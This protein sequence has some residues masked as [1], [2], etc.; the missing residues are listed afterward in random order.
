MWYTRKTLD[1]LCSHR[2]RTVYLIATVI[3]VLSASRLSTMA[4]TTDAVAPLNDNFA[5]PQVL[6]GFS[7][8]GTGTNVAASK[9]TGEPNHAGNAGGHSV[10]YSWTPSSGQLG[11][12]FT[13]RNANTNYDTLLAVYTGTQVN[14]LTQVTANDD[15]GSTPSFVTST[16]YF[17]AVGGTTYMIAVDGFGGITGNF[18]ISWDVNRLHHKN[19]R[20]TGTGISATTIFRP[21]TGT[22]WTTSSTGI[23]SF[24][25]GASG[26]VPTP[27]D[28]DGDLVTDYAIFRNGAW[29]VLQSRTSTYSVTN[30]GLAGDKPMPGDYNGNGYDDY[31]VFRPSNGTW[32]VHDGSSPTSYSQQFGLNLDKPAARD[33]DGDGKLD[34]TVFRPST[35]VWYILNSY[36]QTVSS[37]SWGISED[38]P[39]PGEYFLDGK[40]D[41]AVWRPSNG[42]WYARSLNGVFTKIQAFGLS[43]DIPQALDYGIFTGLSDFGVF[44]PSTGTWYVFDYSNGQFWT[45][46]FGLPGDIPASTSYPIQQ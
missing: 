29:W 12:S 26:D 30:F 25:F 15:Y 28:F 35:G 18:T 39:M 4:Q 32:Y 36:D 24:K 20:F 1:A 3:F 46:Q 8:S 16:V 33:Y 21:S 11:M 19:S 14:A 2:R 23:Q 7:G 27:G 31:A 13:L 38:I 10:W 45:F 6:S 43:G 34:L 37:V 41:I 22:W 9:E 5:S 44:R 17:P 42:T 40:A